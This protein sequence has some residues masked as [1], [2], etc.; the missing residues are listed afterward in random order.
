LRQ[1]AQI[2]LVQAEQ[3]HAG[4]EQQFVGEWIEDGAEFALLIVTSRDVAIHAI[5]DCSEGEGQDCAEPM[6]FIPAFLIRQN[7][8]HKEGNQQ[9]ADDG[10]FVGRSHV[11]AK[12]PAESIPDVQCTKIAQY[13]S[14]PELRP[15]QLRK[16]DKIDCRNRRDNSDRR[17]SQTSIPFACWRLCCLE[18]I[19]FCLVS[20]Q[21]NAAAIERQ[22][23]LG[24]FLKPPISDSGIKAQSELLLAGKVCWC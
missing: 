4:N 22:I 18:T 24:N 12:H 15:K 8:D 10:Y 14:A 7:F 3:N 23:L 5:A 17:E 1:T 9:D 6:K 21:R 20:I 19:V 13:E 2:R 11:G 16:T